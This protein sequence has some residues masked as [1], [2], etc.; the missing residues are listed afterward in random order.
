MTSGDADGFSFSSQTSVSNFNAQYSS[1]LIDWLPVTAPLSISLRSAGKQA[2]AYFSPV[3]GRL[4]P[5]VSFVGV[6]ATV[7]GLDICHR[8]DRRFF[9]DSRV[10]VVTERDKKPLAAAERR[11]FPADEAPV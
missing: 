3:P 11:A 8:G 4:R 9:A 6:V 5:G 1:N 7:A 10:V 2:A